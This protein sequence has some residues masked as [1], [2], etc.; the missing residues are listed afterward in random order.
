MNIYN[1]EKPDKKIK[2]GLKLRTVHY[3]AITSVNFLKRKV[4][5][6]CLDD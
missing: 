5:E 6:Y 3:E 1:N 4:Q 2:L